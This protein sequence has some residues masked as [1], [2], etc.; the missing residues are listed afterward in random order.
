MDIIRYPLHDK[1]QF[2]FNNIKSSLYSLISI[3]LKT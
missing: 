3:N 1:Q 2:Y